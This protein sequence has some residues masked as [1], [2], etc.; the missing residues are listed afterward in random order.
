MRLL[1]LLIVMGCVACGERPQPTP[2]AKPVR[3]RVGALYYFWS[4]P[5]FSKGHLRQRLEVPQ[6]PVAGHYNSLEPTVIKGHIELAAQYGIDFFALVADPDPKRTLAMID[7]YLSV[8]D[9]DELEFC[10]VT[11]ASP[12][13]GLEE[14]LRLLSERLFSQPDYLRFEGRAVV[15][16][17]GAYGWTEAERATLSEIRTRLEAQGQK[18]FLVGD[19]LNWETKSPVLEP[20]F[21]AVTTLQFQWSSQKDRWAGYGAASTLL[22]DLGDASRRA[23][24]GPTP[25]IAAV[26]PGYNSTEPDHYVIGREWKVEAGPGGLFERMLVEFALPAVDPRAPLI[27]VNS[28]NG[29][30]QDTQIEPVAKSPSTFRDQSLDNRFTR[31][32]AYQGYE[33]L[34]LELLRSRILAVTGRVISHHDLSAGGVRVSAYKDGKEVGWDTTDSRG[35]YSLKRIGFENQCQIGTTLAK[36]RAVEIDPSSVSEVNFFVEDEVGTT[37]LFPPLEDEIRKSLQGFTPSEYQRFKIGDDT[38]HGEAPW[39]DWPDELKG[40]LK[41]VVPPGRSAIVVGAGDGFSAIAL[42]RLLGA[43]THVYAMESR[44]RKF[45]LLSHNLQTLDLGQL[46][47]VWNGGQQLD[48]HAPLPPDRFDL[49]GLALVLF[50]SVDDLQLAAGLLESERPLLLSPPLDG[51]LEWEILGEL[52]RLGYRSYRFSSHH[53]LGEFCASN[54]ARMMGDIGEPDFR[55]A[56]T[57]F[58][59]QEREESRSFS[60]STDQEVAISFELKEPVAGSYSI[61]L[62]ARCF[63]PLAPLKVE[64]QLNEK[65]LGTATLRG[66]WGGVQLDVPAG[67]LQAGSNTLV[68]RPARTAR[69]ADHDKNSNDTRDLAICLDRFWVAEAQLPGLK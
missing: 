29:W 34:Y 37:P 38:L 45:R 24:K 10:W 17:Q 66:A 26:I 40:L 35:R 6:E 52:Y 47:P 15:V 11:L 8:E 64:V 9:R 7:A 51:D 1:L 25:L 18:L 2:T 39:N 12:S 14:E 30:H 49:P 44:V 53:W 5:D 28:W 56:L 21:D 50:Q 16:L 20:G 62:L 69:P 46:S 32:F 3:L 27:F 59:G 36:S 61:G 55:E 43:E 60:W 68:L 42:A 22:A 33:E 67:S 23:K 4:P 31:E 57:G 13:Q 54:S 19:A 48:T 63:N 58:G 65:A 41:T